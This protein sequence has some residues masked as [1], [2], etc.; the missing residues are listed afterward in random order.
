MKRWATVVLCPLFVFFLS[1]QAHAQSL[2]LRILHVNDFHGF[3]E[4][5]KPL[6]SRELLGGVAYLAG[7]VKALRQ[8]KPTAPACRRGY[9]PGEQ[10]GQYVSRR[11]GH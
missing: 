9:D 3:A 6:G 5:Y 8:G 10:L 2:D 1:I 11:V 4:A 7:K